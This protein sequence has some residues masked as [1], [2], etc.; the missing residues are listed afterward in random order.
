MNKLTIEIYLPAV[1]Q[2]FDVR[3]PA[4]M[5]L[6]QITQLVSEALAQLSGS[7]YS[8]DTFPILCDQKSGEILNINMTA[9]DLGL[10]NGSRLM[11]I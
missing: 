4:D 1:L 9:W 11:L 2:R 10:R 5:K 7:L 6:S 8:A 3:V